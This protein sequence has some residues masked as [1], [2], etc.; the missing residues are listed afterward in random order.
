MDIKSELAK[1]RDTM[2]VPEIHMKLNSTGEIN[3]SLPTLRSWFYDQRKPSPQNRKKLCK[4]IA[5]IKIKP[6]I[7]TI[8]IRV[9]SGDPKSIHTTGVP[10]GTIKIL[11]Q[12][13]E[14]QN[15]KLKEKSNPALYRDI[16]RLLSVYPNKRLRIVSRQGKNMRRFQQIWSKEVG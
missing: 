3:I 16:H 12:N 4:A 9:T 5:M 6:E 14:I 13:I 8:A 7:T 10:N 2:G 11:G 1:L 15:R